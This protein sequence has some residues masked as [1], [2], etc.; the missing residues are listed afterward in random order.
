MF[1]VLH[2]ALDDDD[3]V[4][5]PLTPAARVK[6]AVSIKRW[7]HSLNKLG[8][9]NAINLTKVTDWGRLP[10]VLL[11]YCFWFFFVL[12]CF[13]PIRNNLAGKK[14]YVV[15]LLPLFG[16]RGTNVA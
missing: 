16:Q 4:D 7:A 10:A 13:Q 5:P 6:S 3:E 8:S 2:D 14:D 1:H 15:P 12:F 11:F 9:I